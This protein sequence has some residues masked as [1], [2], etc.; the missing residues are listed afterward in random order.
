MRQLSFLDRFLTLWIFLAMAVGI[1]IGTFFP[2]FTSGLNNLQIGTTSLPLAIG[3]I[4]MIYPPLS[5]VRYEE[6]GRVFK[7]RK[8]LLLSLIQNWVIGPVLMFLLAI[9]FLPDKP[10]YMVGLIMIGLAR[11]IAMVIVWNDL[12]KGDTEY[13]AGL[14]AFNSVFQMLFFSV[15]AYI[16]VTVIPEWLGIQGAI[17]NITMAEVANSVFIYLGIPFLAGMLTRFVLVKTKGS[18]WYEKVFIPKISPI[19]LIALL[20][21]IIVMFSLKGESIIS[22]PVDVVRIATPLLI[23]FI[24]MFFISFFMGKQIGANYP[25]TTTLAFTAGSNNFELAIAV[26][27][28]VFGIHS[29]AAFAAVIGPLVEV[30]VMIA[31]VNVALWFKRKYFANTYPY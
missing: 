6:M 26:A 12:A 18:H 14:V 16:F 3:L 24:I 17:V 28:G 10:E 9:I 15:Y 2:A 13:A 25:V 29:G 21:T 27:V 30:P 7:D 8:V 1:S 19:T 11:C 20:F 4:L 31:L 22:V 5:K 23:Y